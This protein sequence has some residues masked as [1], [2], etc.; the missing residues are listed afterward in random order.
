MCVFLDMRIILLTI[1][2]SIQLEDVQDF[3][4]INANQ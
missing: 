2:I 3:L 1:R 4:N